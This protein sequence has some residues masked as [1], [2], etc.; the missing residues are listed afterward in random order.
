MKPQIIKPNSN[1]NKM[2]T[3]EH[4]QNINIRPFI[5]R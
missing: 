5:T 1:I 2:H 3:L 4:N